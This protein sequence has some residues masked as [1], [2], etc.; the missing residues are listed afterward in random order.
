MPTYTAAAPSRF[1]ATRLDSRVTMSL[2]PITPA[3]AIQLGIAAQAVASTAASTFSGLL[4]EGMQFLS[5]VTGEPEASASGVSESPSGSRRGL[6][7]ERAS[8]DSDL[9]VLRAQIGSLLK[10]LH[11]EFRQLFQDNGLAFPSTGVT[12]A[13]QA[14]GRIELEGALADKGHLQHLLEGH[15][16]LPSLIRAVA[17]R[18]RL[19]SKVTSPANDGSAPERQRGVRVLVN[20]AGAFVVDSRR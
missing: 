7:A 10:R 1:P 18:Q 17:A 12:L 13:Q 4:Q 20:S 14:D 9:N 15:D 2:P 16:S 8:G 5:N 11:S 3:Q 19:L 6:A